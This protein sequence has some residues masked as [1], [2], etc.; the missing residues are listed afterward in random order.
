MSIAILPV[1]SPIVNCTLSVGQ[2]VKVTANVDFYAGK[3]GVVHHIR[4]A[5]Q[6]VYVVLDSE[7]RWLDPWPLYFAP[8]EIEVLS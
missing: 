6:S 8:Y 3:L 1:S 4:D 7:P 2:R 5:G